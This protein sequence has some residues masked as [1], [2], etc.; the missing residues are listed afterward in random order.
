MGDP[1]SIKIGR[2]LLHASWNM[3][4][5]SKLE[6]VFVPWFKGHTFALEGPW[7]PAEITSLVPMLGSGLM[8]AFPSAQTEIAG[9]LLRFNVNALYNDYNY[10]LRS[11]QA[12]LRF[13]TSL[14]SSDFGFQYYY[15]RLPRPAFSINL[16][17]FIPTIYLGPPDP[18]KIEISMG[19][20]FYHQIGVD[21][22]RVVA[23]FNLRAEAALNLTSD[24]DGTDGGVYNPFFAWSLGFDRD[25]V[26][27]INLNLQGNG[28]IRLFQSKLG[29]NM[30]VDMEA[31][32]DLSS[33]RITAILSK[34]FFRDELELKATGLWGIED[35]DFLIIPAVIWSKNDV[36]AEL[37][38]GFFGGDRAGELG[39]YKD[40]SYLKVALGYSF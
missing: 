37:A 23:G 38:A 25:L 1:Q 17:N 7:A 9:W 26:W 4:T 33:T 29:D 34:K 2:P 10:T 5:Y 19:Y 16:D 18:E 35:K 20:N 27:G 8:S 22:A 31:G 11:A 36:T 12:G 24:T 40:N 6:A 39:Q 15:G 3:G 14:N 13:T 30:L 32:K 28:S 21:F